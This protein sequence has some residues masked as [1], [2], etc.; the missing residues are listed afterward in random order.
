MSF[1]PATAVAGVAT[2]AHA[3]VVVIG[4]AAASTTIAADVVLLVL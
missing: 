1:I 3:T 4:V 2:I